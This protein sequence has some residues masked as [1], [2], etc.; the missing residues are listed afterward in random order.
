MENEQ[1]TAEGGIEIIRLVTSALKERK[2]GASISV[3][4]DEAGS[5]KKEEMLIKL[6]LPNDA[7]A[8]PL[9]AANLSRIATNDIIMRQSIEL[10]L[11]EALTN[12]IFH[13][14]LEIPSNL[15]ERDF[16]AYYEM[17]FKRLQEGP[18]ADRRVEVAF[19]FDDDQAV[20][21][22]ADQGRG[23]DWRPFLDEKSCCDPPNGRGL[24]IMQALTSSVSFNE[25]GNR[26]TLLFERGDWRHQPIA[27]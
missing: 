14:N 21:R 19:S 16:N 9:V 2:Y 27:A 23:F 8:I 13:G 17:A 3:R 10:A 5:W 25:T 12:A 4:L 18:Y 1:S 7:K 26:V 20:F 24:K 15:K 6:E 11:D 22:I